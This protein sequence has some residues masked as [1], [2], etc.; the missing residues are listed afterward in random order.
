MKCL[1]KVRQLFGGTFK[2]ETIYPLWNYIINNRF[3]VPDFRL[4]DKI[5]SSFNCGVANVCATHS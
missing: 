2:A 1:Q 4:S 5:Q 3:P